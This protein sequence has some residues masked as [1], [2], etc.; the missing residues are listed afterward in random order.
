LREGK[1]DVLIGVNLLREGLICQVSMV[2]IL[3]D[4]EGFARGAIADSNHRQSSSSCAGKRFYM[5]TTSPI[6]WQLETRRR[7][8]IQL[9][10][11]EKQDYA[12]ADSQNLLTQFYLS[13]KCR[14][15]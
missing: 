6:A 9:E 4:K 7:R 13:W 14:G 12:A 2:A 10:Y 11:N 3:A 8:A 15:G 1:F 5:P